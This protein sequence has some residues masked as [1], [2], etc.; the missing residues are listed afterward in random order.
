MHLACAFTSHKTSPDTDVSGAVSGPPKHE[1]SKRGP[2]VRDF[3]ARSASLSVYIYIYI[4]VSM[5]MFFSYVYI[6][7]YMLLIYGF[8][9]NRIFALLC[10]FGI[11]RFRLD[12]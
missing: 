3:Q 9:Q 7:R 1:P 5:Y 10:T 12:V 8:V 6:F 11:W 2:V 4:C